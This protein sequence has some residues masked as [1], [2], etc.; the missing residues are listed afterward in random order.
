M[1]K[2][3][4]LAGLLIF[5]LIIFAF[6]RRSV[7]SP[8]N[9]LPVPAALQGR[10]TLTDT[11]APGNGGP[12]VWSQ[13]NPSG[14]WINIEQGG[15]VSGTAFPSATYCVAVDS[16]TVKLADPSQ[17]AGFRL[18]GYHIDT[19]SHELFF[20]IRPPDGTTYCIEGCGAYEFVR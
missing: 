9:G 20:Y 18:F 2:D 17:P 6:C 1:K 3:S 16:V 11:Q 10:W 4:V 14:Q 12:G 5:V 8:V 15:Q 7:N 13:A 19:V